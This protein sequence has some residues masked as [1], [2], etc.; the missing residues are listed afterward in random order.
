MLARF[1]RCQLRKGLRQPFLQLVETLD[2]VIV[3][4]CGFASRN[5]GRG[6]EPNFLADMVEG[7]HL[8]KKQQAGVGNAELILCLRGQAFDLA[9]SVVSE[10]SNR[11]GGKRRQARQPCRFVPAQRVAQNGKNIAGHA[12][13]FLALRDGNLAAA[14][15]D[16]LKR[17]EPNEGIT[18]HLLAALDRFQK[19][20]LP[21]PPGRA[22]EC[23][24]RSFQVGHQRAVNGNQR[25]RSGESQKLLA[26]G[27]G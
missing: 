11:S 10:K 17:G 6:H 19:K 18:A 9:H 15:H 7:E 13:G 22:Q 4:R 26:A 25:V 1:S 5:V 12:R 27:M 8:V 3:R 2:R 14:R 21:L 16:P 23:R 24:N 20:A